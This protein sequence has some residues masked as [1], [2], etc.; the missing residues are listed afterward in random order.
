MRL[1]WTILA[2]IGCVKELPKPAEPEVEEAT[3]S[4][5]AEATL[6]LNQLTATCTRGEAEAHVS[7]AREAILRNDG[8]VIRTELGWFD[9]WLAA[10]G[11]AGTPPTTPAP[12][13]AG[14]EAEL[15]RAGA[16]VLARVGETCGACHGM[17]GRGPTYELLAQPTDTSG[18]VP[19]M[20]RHLWVTDRLW[21]GLSGP[22]EL[23]WQA[24]LTALLARPLPDEGF[25]GRE[26][27]LASPAAELGPWLRRIG[28]VALRTG[29]PG[30]RAELY[31]DLLTTCAECHAGTRG[32]PDPQH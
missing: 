2:L 10:Q 23:R 24:G 22:S 6:A 16:L 17:T 12:V 8:D 26:E 29:D 15:A 30:E 18:V 25:E 13:D 14:Q 27:D 7:R 19:H 11:Q 3:P 1:T 4:T 32:A 31:A 20:R 21:E 5:V 28:L 9:A